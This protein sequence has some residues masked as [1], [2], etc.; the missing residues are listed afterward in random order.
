M[1]GHLTNEQIDEVLRSN[2]LCRLGCHDGKKTYIVPLNY[3]FDGKGIIAHS[4][5]GMKIEM[6]RKNPNVCFEVDQMKSFTNWKS[7]VAWGKFQELT[8]EDDQ[9]AALELFIEKMMHMKLSETSLPHKMMGEK[10]NAHYKGQVKTVIFRIIIT[11]KTGRFEN[12]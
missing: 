3:A 10:G 1:I 6:M 2:V 9:Q 5:E 12:E 11:E 8:N 7:V 4:A